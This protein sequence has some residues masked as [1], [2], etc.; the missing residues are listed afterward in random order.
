MD[1]KTSNDIV[2]Q[3]IVKVRTMAKRTSTFS[4]KLSAVQ[5]ELRQRR[6]QFL[7]TYLPVR[8]FVLS[9]SDLDEE[10]VE[11]LSDYLARQTISFW[12][13][14]TE[15][16][17]SFCFRFYRLAFYALASGKVSREC[18]DDILRL[19][20]C[21][22]RSR[23]VFII[24]MKEMLPSDMIGELYDFT[25]SYNDEFYTVTLEEAVLGGI[26]VLL[27]VLSSPLADTEQE[28]FEED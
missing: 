10:I 9:G 5:Q 19:A 24:A 28:H 14:Q 15:D 3:T 6:K 17:E 8:E 2:M 23:E 16:A 7:G 11:A 22:V 4:D 18:V 21:L 20:E 25:E 13:N 27:G 26:C 1:K 12:N